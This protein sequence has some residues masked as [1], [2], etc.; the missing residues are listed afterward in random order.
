MM[1]LLQHESYQ[2][3]IK[4]MH[5]IVFIAATYRP[6]K[7]DKEIHADQFEQ[8]DKVKLHVNFARFLQ[9]VKLFLASNHKYRRV[10][11][12]IISDE[13]NFYEW[14]F[15]QDDDDDCPWRPCRIDTFF[16]DCRWVRFN[17][18]GDYGDGSPGAFFPIGDY[19]FYQVS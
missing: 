3:P 7:I 1:N 9:T 15:F 13:Y 2:V 11:G 19:E 18:Y 6:P 14:P 5:L 8:M 4:A 10:E 17:Y 16:S 12:M